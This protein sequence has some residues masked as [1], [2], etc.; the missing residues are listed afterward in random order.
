M[1]FT[2]LSD[3]FT[4]LIDASNQCVCGSVVRV[5]GGLCPR[6][7]LEI[8]IDGEYLSE[9]SFES[10]LAEINIS[11]RD[12]RLGSYQILEE[13]ARGG[14]GVIYRARHL[15]S[16][17]IV[18]L[19]R[20]LTYHSDSQ[21][22]L[23]RFQQ[24]A[25]A[26][27]SL[28]HPNIL[29]I[30][31]VG[32]TD[33]GLPYFSMKLATG[34][35]LQSHKPQIFGDARSASQMMSK[36]A[37]AIE[38][39]HERG[40]VHRD[41]K[42][43]NILLDACDEPMVADFGLAKW[44]DRG[45]DLTCTLTVFGTPGYIAPEQAQGGVT[46]RNHSVDIYSLGVI[47]FELLS[48][49]PPFLGEH[50]IDVIRQATEKPAPR[51]RS[52]N[53]TVARDL[54][55]ICARCL[56]REPSRRYRSARE[57]GEDIDRW[58]EDRPIVA[59]PV[60]PPTRVWRWA[61]RNRALAG[62]VCTS[63]ALLATV[64]FRQFD[65]LRLGERIRR[66]QIAAH[67]FAVM[68]FLN[69]DEGTADT[70]LQDRITESLSRQLSLIGPARVVAVRGS[71]VRW[72]GTG[73]ATEVKA[74]LGQ[75]NC[76]VAVVG[77]YRRLPNGVRTSLRF[78]DPTSV[79]AF[80]TWATDL[81][82]T[83][84]AVKTFETSTVVTSAF[85]ALDG[86]EITRGR[87]EDPIF[88]DP[89]ARAYYNAGRSLLDRRTIP[90]IDRAIN[91][92]EAAIK[93][94]PQS[95]LARSYLALALMGRNFLTADRTY[96]SQAYKVAEEALKLSPND[97]SGHHALCAI[98][99]STGHFDHALE[100]GYRALELGDPTERVLG[101]IAYLWKELGRP[102]R[103]LQWFA[104]AKVS[105]DQPADYDALMG[106][107][108]SLLAE[109]N[110]AIEAY[111]RAAQFRPDLPE[112]WLGL[113]HLKLLEG[114][115]DEARSLF[116]QRRNEYSG[117]PNACLLEAQIEFFGRNFTRAEQ[118]YSEVLRTNPNGVATEQYGAISP[119]S[120]LALL[121]LAQGRSGAA[122]DLIARAAADD[123]A[124]LSISPR[125]P[126]V[127]YRLAADE[128][129]QGD[130]QSALT[131]LKAS[132]EAGHVDYRSLQLDPRFDA[133]ADSAEFRAIVS[134]LAA[135]VTEL[136]ERSLMK[137]AKQR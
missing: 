64:V 114:R 13:I 37:R 94:A 67:S 10:E 62:S 65:S 80:Q 92:F 112:G 54:E 2:G 68:P 66:E 88:A 127:L 60:S 42:P 59:R 31:D 61:R 27:A 123:R 15:P 137:V 71:S 70:D 129:V 38:F 99:I 101:Q 17:R 131:H 126:E 76:R 14:M 113:C 119:A 77:M 86:S 90:D 44:L 41:L 22:T 25:Q 58:L 118:L 121:W 26:A 35:S 11:D 115:I 4:G 63:I 49:R 47:F 111:Q 24:E 124:A 97:S 122:K 12:W 82:T 89:T 84:D 133:I 40:V 104:K 102:D 51:L 109:D 105:E 136:R 78:I 18:A 19:K 69:L 55:T 46:K 91:C 117:F 75:S 83:V 73:T 23:A 9:T 21:E 29:P 110:G 32:L 16:K 128:A 20:V 53:Q 107:A 103:A 1:R 93:A 95:V 7:L 50:A 34:G 74:A 98:D 79:G 96:I 116:A 3:S 72:T 28:E 6:C 132:I 130:R 87:P 135:H 43:A 57:L 52:I 30:Y 36:I 33:D 85:R 8:V 106:D 100:H 45:A 134:M 125:Q 39:A 5:C 56:D 120:G 48:G 108:W 81:P